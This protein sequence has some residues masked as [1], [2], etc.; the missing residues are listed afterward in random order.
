MRRAVH[1]IA[2]LD[3]AE[4]SPGRMQRPL[5][6][7]FDERLVFAPVMDQVGDRADLQPVMRGKR[8]QLGQPRHRAVVVHHLADHRRG[9][10]ARERREIAAGLGVPRTHEHAAGA[11]GDR[12]HVA[13]LHQIVR[14]SAGPHR[15]TDRVCAIGRRN[16]G[17]HAVGRLDADGERGA[18][19]RAVVIGHRRQLQLLAALGGQREADQPAP[20]ARHEIDRV[21]RHVISRDHEI[22]FVLAILF[23]DEQDHP[24]R[25]QFVDDLQ[26]AGER[27]RASVKSNARRSA[28]APKV[29]T[30]SAASIAPSMLA[31]P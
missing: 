5:A 8:L 17:R 29:S 22:A 12:E 4:S 3:R 31:K 9:R 24:A 1:R 20:E 30:R 21:G 26:R 25:P 13:G 28:S 11:R 27:H 7:A 15:G 10:E 23:V 2:I 16:A 18:E 6:D 19:R 14:A